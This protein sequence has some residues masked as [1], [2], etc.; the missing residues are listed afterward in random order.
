MTREGLQLGTGCGNLRLGQGLWRREEGWCRPTRRLV[1]ADQIAFGSRVRH[2]W[3]H[4]RIGP[5]GLI[6]PP[7]VAGRGGEIDEHEAVFEDHTRLLRVH[8]LRCRP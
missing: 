8:P 4:R 7:A 3:R 2:S 5:T 6:A 1:V